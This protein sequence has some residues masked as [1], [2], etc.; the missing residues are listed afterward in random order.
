MSLLRSKR[1]MAVIAALLLLLFLFRPAVH[2]LRNR[3]SN[4]IASA[5]GRRVSID[6]VRFR[7]LPRPGFD[8]EGL[9]IYD[10]P[11]F[12]AEPMIR[13][14]D[15]FAAIRFRSLVRGRLEIATLSASEPSI[16]IVRNNEG[17]WNLAS[18]IERNAQIPAAPTQKA[19]SERRPAFPYLEA[20]GARINFKIGQAKKS[21]ALTD[22]DV[23]L[24][25]ESEN[26]WG[27]R[28]KAQPVRTDFNLTD[29]GLLRMDATWQRASNLHQTPMQFSVAWQKGQLGQ[30]T[31]L[32]TGKDRGWRG[33]VDLTAKV[34]GTPEALMIENR[35]AINGFHRYDIFD[36]RSVRLAARCTATYN[37]VTNSLSSLL[38]EAPV[39]D[40]RIRLS[41]NA[42]TLTTNPRYDLTLAAEK[43]PVA[44]VLELLHEAK[45]QL[46]DDLTADGS[47]DAEFHAVRNGSAPARLTGTGAAAGVHLSSNGGKDLVAVGAIPLMLVSQALSSKPTR[48]GTKQNSKVNDAEPAEAHLRIGPAS[49]VANSAAPISA[50][51]WISASGYRFFLRGDT[52]LK[53]L[54][55]L[56]N[57]FG[58]PAVHPA[59]E[60]EAVLDVSIAGP[61]Q[62]L[63]AP[64][65][66]G[67]VQ[68]RNV[69][70]EMRGLRTPIEIVSAVIS[71]VPDLTLAQKISARTGDTH[72]NGTVTARRDCAP[73]CLYVYEF[74]LA[75]DGL[76]TTDF[77]EW[78]APHPGKRPWYR[79]LGTDEPSGPSP[80]L[81]LKADG[82]LRVARFE[83]GKVRATQV[84]AT[85]SVDHGK[86]SLAIFRAGL[87]A[88][89]HRGHWTIDTSAHPLRCHGEGTIQN[90]SLAQVGELMN[91]PWISGG[92]DGSFD[93]EMSGGSLRDLLAK[94][95][96]KL[97][98]AMRNGS[99]AHVEIP[100][101]NGPL[102]VYRFTG[103]LQ[104]KNGAWKLS[105]GRLESHDGIYRVS[106]TASASN[107]IDFVL[108]RGDEQAW[109]VT[110]TLAEPEAALVD[111]TEISAEASQ[112]AGAQ[113][114]ARSKPRP[115]R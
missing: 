113:A 32:L 2:G 21:F 19:A 58:I 60:G 27:A 69:R 93:L 17:R 86:I 28:L 38:C 8:L 46:P 112:K 103:D 51:G 44:S 12:S 62:G 80:L 30:I 67:T 111:R 115:E 88:G 35:G 16:N 79:I 7:F 39:R 55:R 85:V 48:V 24:W 14:Q 6:E 15:V 107:G 68:L 72:W 52:G 101:G 87:L 20:S 105:R 59:A 97:Q 47:V 96:G 64:L 99:F 26:S 71:L 74:D 77:A 40:G 25:Q 56:E 92:V 65:T 110:G 49:L 43:V 23:A 18:L 13:A 114:T 76:S 29:T 90:V 5:L 102:P 54:F 53:N 82:R 91:D 33:G 1:G 75:A 9:V 11:A 78:V 34:I 70:A 61:W 98:F 89:T 63:V 36:R 4:S 45:K 100:E 42:G 22:A 37:A 3:I 94:S 84:T 108:T 41:G 104:L 109:N 10:D 57:I 66:C 95:D 31:Q 50:G 83:I 81:G 73:A 106:G